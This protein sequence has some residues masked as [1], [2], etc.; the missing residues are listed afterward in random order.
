L[1]SYHLASGID[2]AEQGITEVVRGADLLNCTPS[3]LYVQNVLKLNSP[4]YC[5]L[6]V[7]VSENGQKLSKQNYARPIIADDAGNLLVKTLHF[8]GQMP[9]VEL[10]NSDKKE[11]WNWAMKN[12]QLDLV[13][14]KSQQV[15]Y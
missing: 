9:P 8:L 12:W 2:D 10:I 3:Q 14:V 13:P 15:S 7:A 4:Q 5:H 1:F 11:V 6:P